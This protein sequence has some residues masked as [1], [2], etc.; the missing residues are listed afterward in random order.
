MNA[1]ESTTHSDLRALAEILAE[2]I[3]AAPGSTWSLFYWIF[4]GRE[5]FIMRNAH[6]TVWHP[7][8]EL[9][10][11]IVLKLYPLGFMFVQEPWFMGVP[12][13]R[14]YLRKRDDEDAELPI[15][16]WRRD[17]HPFWPVVATP[18]SSIMLGGDTFGL[19]ARRD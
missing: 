15:E 12:N 10:Q 9:R 8:V 18:K 1:C 6:H 11:M 19:V 3:K 4:V 17:N 13:M 14:S 7:T 5:L 16:F 2:W